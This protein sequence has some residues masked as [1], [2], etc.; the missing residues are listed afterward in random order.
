MT[1]YIS[2]N[3]NSKMCVIPYAVV[4]NIIVNN[5]EILKFAQRW[6]LCNVYVDTKQF[7]FY[8]K[9]LFNHY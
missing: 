2:K 6:L 4:C 8:L 1:D 7:D 3:I 9:Q 5:A